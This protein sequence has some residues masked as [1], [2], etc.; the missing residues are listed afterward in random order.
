ME[1]SKNHYIDRNSSDDKTAT[2]V[3]PVVLHN[4][5]NEIRGNRM[6]NNR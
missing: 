5:E 2:D 1:E 6:A 3:S 4:R